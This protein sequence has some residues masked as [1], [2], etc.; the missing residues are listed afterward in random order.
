[1]SKL[2]F[3]SM[4]WF[5]FPVHA[6]RWSKCLRHLLGI[7]HSPHAFYLADSEFNEPV[8]KKDADEI[9]ISSDW[10]FPA[11]PD[12]LL[13]LIELMS[14][15]GKQ[16]GYTYLVVCDTIETIDRMFCSQGMLSR[17]YI[18]EYRKRPA[19]FVHDLLRG[20]LSYVTSTPRG[21][22]Y[23][24]DIERRRHLFSLVNPKAHPDPLP[25]VM[26]HRRENR[27][28]F[29]SSLRVEGW[30]GQNAGDLSLAFQIVPSLSSAPVIP[31]KNQFNESWSPEVF[32]A[33]LPKQIKLHRDEKLWDREIP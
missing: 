23:T 10:N 29:S 11:S 17:S 3:L 19:K 1:M 12:S 14:Q 25:Y 2:I 16:F 8:T 18:N 24:Y 13:Q 7:N 22:R 27:Q 4:V 33:Q 26:G 31:I 20:R 28:R 30:P 32:S 21:D 15:E 9:L 6:S 5:T